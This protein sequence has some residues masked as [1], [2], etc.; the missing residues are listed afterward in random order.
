VGDLRVGLVGCGR[1]A[2]RGYVPALQR[3][4][5]VRLAAVAD[6]VPARCAGVAP[7]VP[8]FA[9]A[10]ELIDA[11]AADALVLATPAARHLADAQAAC[12]AGIA[13]LVEKP[14]APTAAEAAELARLDPSPF[15]GFN[16]RF[17]PAL[18]ELRRAAAATRSLR[19]RLVL[20]RRRSSWPSYEAADPVALDLGPHLVDLAFWLSGAEADRVAGRADENRMS[21]ELELSGGR[22]SASIECELGRPYRELVEI[23]GIGSFA[24]GGWRT[25]LRAR[26]SP[27]VASL[28]RELEAFARAARGDVTPELATAHDGLRVMRVLERVTS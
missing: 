11:R 13:T 26:E 6:P 14:P 17:E 23:S 2:E 7:G 1:I 12:V 19:L 5:G 10:A 22:G 3:A 20:R 18:E 25:A 28:T 27:L 15:V 4:D 9:S 24:R 16:R 8:A 21:L